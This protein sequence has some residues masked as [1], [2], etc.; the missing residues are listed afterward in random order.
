MRSRAPIV[1]I[2]D[3]QWHTVLHVYLMNVIRS[4]RLVAPIMQ[5]Q[6]SGAIINI[7][8]AWPFE[9]SA[10]FPTSAVFRA[11]RLLPIPRSSPTP[12]ARGQRAYEQ[13]PARLDRQPAGD[14]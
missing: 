14:G 6:K 13:R 10:M 8:T 9:L 4:V 3:E 2:T 7:S 11:G 12:Y 5:K 1:E